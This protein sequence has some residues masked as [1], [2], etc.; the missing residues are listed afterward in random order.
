MSQGIG[1]QY[2]LENAER[3]KEDLGLTMRGK[4]M[5]LPKYYRKLLDI[6]Q[7]ILFEKS[8]EANAELLEIYRKRYK[9]KD[10]YPAI[11]KHQT[12]SEKNIK[13][14]QNQKTKGNF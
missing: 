7:E 2:V 14:K 13:A 8:K 9:D 1:K 6:P 10:I 12:Q 3:L 4:E 11:M 5:G